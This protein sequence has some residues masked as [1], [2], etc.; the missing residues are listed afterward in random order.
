MILVDI[1]MPKSCRDCPIVHDEIY[2]SITHKSVLDQSI[3][4]MKER[5]PD[6]PLKQFVQPPKADFICKATAE[7]WR[8]FFRIEKTAPQ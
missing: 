4:F 2:C 7:E 5:L 3:D 8:K 1:E 6:C